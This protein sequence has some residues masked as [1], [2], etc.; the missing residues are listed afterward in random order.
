VS[1]ETEDTKLARIS[2]QKVASSVLAKPVA[3]K[4]QQSP[5]LSVTRVTLPTFE[6]VYRDAEGA[7]EDAQTIRKN[8]AFEFDRDLQEPAGAELV[9]ELSFA[10]VHFS[11]TLLFRVIGS[12]GGKT[13][14]EWWARRNT[15]SKLLALWLESLEPHRKQGQQDSPALDEVRATGVL[16]AM[17]IYRRMLSAN[18]FD[19]LGLHWTSNAEL[20]AEAT[21][22][23]LR[24]L[25]NRLQATEADEQVTLYLVPCR[26]RVNQ[27]AEILAPLEGRR[28]VRLKMVPPRELENARKQAEH[29][30]QLANRG[31]KPGAI[32]NAEQMLA[33]VSV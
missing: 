33:E 2:V 1:Q 4:V 18:P 23:V 31:G 22:S 28:A 10:E 26:K 3:A 16:E 30:L 13:A 20:V 29:I 32:H 21:R 24:D 15:D 7:Y 6:V 14:L 27:A 8:N 11:I 12:G 17:E 5:I 9:L 19:V 25:E